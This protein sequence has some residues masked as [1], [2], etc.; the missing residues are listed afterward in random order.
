[1]APRKHRVAVGR[2]G[3][4]GRGRGGGR[5]QEVWAWRGAWA[6]APMHTSLKGAINLSSIFPLTLV[7]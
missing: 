5:G 7:S 6:W 1:V 2:D 3:G 4:R